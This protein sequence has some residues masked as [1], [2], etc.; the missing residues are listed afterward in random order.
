M[1]V[2]SSYILQVKPRNSDAYISVYNITN[3]KDVLCLLNQYNIV[4]I[5]TDGFSLYI[6]KAD[7]LDHSTVIQH[8][9]NLG[10]VS[11]FTGCMLEKPVSKVSKMPNVILPF[12]YDKDILFEALRKYNL[13]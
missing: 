6:W 7:E 5:L 1:S 13:Y 4:R 8:L 2:D 11:N 10:I 12:D 3:G 9:Q